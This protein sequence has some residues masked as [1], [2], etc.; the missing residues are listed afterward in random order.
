MPS[1]TDLNDLARLAQAHGI[2]TEFEDWK[3][4]AVQVSDETLIA[5]LAALDVDASSPQDV[6]GALA[7]AKDAAASRTLP[8]CTVVVEG[9]SVEISAHLPDGGVRCCVVTEEGGR[10]EVEQ[11]AEEGAPRVADG[12]RLV[13][14]TLRVAG[15]LPLGYHEV[16]VEGDDGFDARGALI[17]TPARL[18]YPASMGEHRVWGL[19]TQLYSVRSRSSWGVGD[20]GDLR[21]LAVWSAGEHGADYILVNPLHAAQPVPPIEPSPYLP[22]SRRFVNPLYLRV[23]LIEEYATAADDVRA[24]IDELAR[25]AHELLDGGERIERDLAWTLKR[26]A[27]RALWDAGRAPGREMAFRAYCRDAGEGL[28]RFA[29]WCV[30]SEQHGPDWS[31][32]PDALRAPHAKE[33]EAFCRANAAELDFYRWMQWCLDEQLRAVQSAACGAGMA[34]GVV[35]DLAVG[36]NPRGADAWA[37]GEVF[38]RGIHVG[39]PPDQFSQLGQDWGQ[40]PL[41]PDALVESAYRPFRDMVRTVLRHAGGVRVDHILGL[42]RL[43]WVPEGRSPREGTYVRYD[44][45][46]MIGILVLE[47]HRAGALVVGE[48]LGTLEKWVQ[49]YLASRGL[50]GTSILWFEQDWDAERPLPPDAWRELCLASVTTHDLPPTAGYLG[51]AHVRLRDELGLLENSLEEELARDEADHR[52]WR[53]FLV[54]QGLLASAD[55]QND[56]VIEALHAFLL[57]TPARMLNV[58]LVDAVGDEQVQNQPGTADEYPNWRVPLCDGAGRPMLLEDAFTSPRAAHLLALFAEV[59]T[60][61]ER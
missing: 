10:V 54:A 38:A 47:A 30:L 22:T 34:L 36:V 42:F 50:L 40:P 59:G 6:Q 53:D 20:L 13:G 5:V 46:A 8:A 3:G 17:V 55:A 37:L 19:A 12:R 33:V 44:H 61:T 32:W 43:W 28:T 25:R 11:A 9:A 45:E 60:R 35:H 7:A 21:D 57:T 4:N 39:A 58:A 15:E 27:L 18:G 41:R 51:A 16:V 49:T 2:A 48:D 31:T 29:A 1:T 26:E 23:E 56:A 14:V 52:R 24:R